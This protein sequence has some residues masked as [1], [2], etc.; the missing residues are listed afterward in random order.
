MVFYYGR[1]S[2]PISSPLRR[3]FFIEALLFGLRVAAKGF[4]SQTKE[5]RRFDDKNPPSLF[6]SSANLLFQ[7]FIFN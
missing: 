1:R 5:E 4:L 7:F 6:P 2:F 3:G